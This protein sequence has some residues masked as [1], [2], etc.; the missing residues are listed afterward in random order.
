MNNQ[1]LVIGGGVAGVQAALDLAE[2]GAKVV[3]V[4]RSPSLGGTMAA[5]DKNFP[6]LDCSICIEAP[7]LAD[8]GAHPN[9]EVLANAEVVGL[10]GEAGDF[11]A[12]IRQR[13][14]F[15]TDECT[16]C[17]LCVDACPVPL[18]NEFEHAMSTRKA[19]YTPFPQAVPGAYTIDVDHCLNDP[20][21]YLP[22]GRCV[23][24]CPPKCIDFN[25]PR[26]QELERNVVSV[27]AATGFETMPADSLVEF[28]YGRHPDILTAMEFERLLAATGPS[29]GEII[30]PSDGAHAEKLLFVLCVGSRDVRHFRYCSRVCCMYSIKEAYQALD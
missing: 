13:A 14:R 24:A 18:P 3:L 12:T 21:N 6:T 30:R 25:Q 4:E 20:P 10:E 29:G 19:I 28:G 26:V 15:V 2:A 8:V 5:L 27:I 9:V 1:V 7:K 17:N 16:R 23:A 11:R 22:C